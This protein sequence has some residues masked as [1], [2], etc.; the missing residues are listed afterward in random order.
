MVLHMRGL[1]ST[2]SEDVHSPIMRTRNKWLSRCLHECTPEAVSPVLAM[3][4][5][6]QR[7]HIRT[8]SAL[9][10][11]VAQGSYPVSRGWAVYGLCGEPWPYLLGGASTH[12]SESMDQSPSN[13]D[14]MAVTLTTLITLVALTLTLAC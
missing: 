10:L 11:A 5:L 13:A 9:C 6:G 1:P 2:L 3:A 4:A 14:S 7:P 8:R 12:V